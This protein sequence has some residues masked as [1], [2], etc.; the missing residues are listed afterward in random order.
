MRE[1][2][3]REMARLIPKSSFYLTE[4]GSHL[5]MWDDQESYFKGLLGF[6]KNLK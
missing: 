5:S 3:I 6:L 4:N 1:D 2:D